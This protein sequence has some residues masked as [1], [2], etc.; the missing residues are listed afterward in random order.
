VESDTHAVADPHGGGH[1]GGR[2]NGIYEFVL[3]DAQQIGMLLRGSGVA[4]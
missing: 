3:A 4:M 2:L 1:H